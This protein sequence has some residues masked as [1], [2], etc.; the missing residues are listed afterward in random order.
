MPPGTM[1]VNGK[2]VALINVEGLILYTDFLAVLKELAAITTI[3]GAR[4]LLR[5]DPR[6]LGSALNEF[7]KIARLS[8]TAVGARSSQ[9]GNHVS[10]GIILASFG[11]F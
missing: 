1:V 10:V 2:N 3:A 4:V 8:T 11:F 5:D 9:I 6:M 7:G